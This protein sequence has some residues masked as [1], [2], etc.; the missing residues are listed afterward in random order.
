MLIRLGCEN[1]LVGLN[2]IVNATVA[3]V[4]SPTG[5]VGQSPA[6]LLARIREKQVLVRLKILVN[7]DLSKILELLTLLGP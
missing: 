2:S 7:V 6:F 1:F 5:V 4:G 3:L